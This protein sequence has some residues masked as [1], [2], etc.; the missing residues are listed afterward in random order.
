MNFHWSDHNDRALQ[1]V[2]LVVASGLTEKLW[3]CV[4]HLS[5]FVRI[6]CKA[7][8]VFHS[9]IR[10]TRNSRLSHSSG[11]WPGPWSSATKAGQKFP[12]ITG[13]ASG[14]HVYT[15][16]GV[17]ICNQDTKNKKPMHTDCPNN[18]PLLLTRNE[19]YRCPCNEC[20]Q[21]RWRQYWKR[22]ATLMNFVSGFYLFFFILIAHS[23]FNL[24]KF[25]ILWI[26]AWHSMHKINHHSESYIN[27]L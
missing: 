10:G 16:N 19:R 11:C 4:A 1:H 12:A 21:D 3:C 25:D 17:W 23:V 26:C 15:E 22:S 14:W 18:H 9:R 5:T 8:Y 7:A 27:P 13:N 24:S 2:F 6:C 20:L